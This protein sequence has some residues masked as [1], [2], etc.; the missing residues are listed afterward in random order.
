MRL[1]VRLTVRADIGESIR[2]VTVEQRVPI[3][4]HV[5]WRMCPDCN[6]EYTN[7]T[8][9][10][11]VQLRQKRQD[12]SKKALILLEAAIAKNSDIRKHVLSVE[13]SKNGFD[14]Y[15][16]ELMHAHSFSAFLSTVYPMKIKFAKKLV[17]EDKKNNSAN[18]KHTTVCDMVPFNRHDLIVC[19]KRAA[20]EGCS[21]GRLNGRM[22]LVNKVSSTL[23]LVDAAPMRIDIED[24]FTDLHPE[25]YWKGEKNFRIIFSHKRLIRFVVMDAELCDGLHIPGQSDASKHAL[26]DVVVARESDFGHSDETFHCTTH[27]GNLL[28]IGD[29]VLGYDLASAVLTGNDEWSMNN[30]FNSSFNVPDVVLVKKVHSGAATEEVVKEAQTDEKKKSKSSA[31]KRRERRKI[32]E[33]KKMK[34]A[35]EG[36][37]R[38][39]FTNSEAINKED[40]NM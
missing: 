7:R 12:D 27:L 32:K 9:Q 33:E 10:A 1:K 22:C 20:K 2:A 37:G 6:R 29:I 18:I 28:D 26:A 34:E 31:S 15:F 11:L 14:F 30:S 21:A 25:K 38:M 4:L 35:A 24:C 23:Q 17:S 39:G 19:D 5:H 16:I 8:W 13:I 40:D 3:E 36:L